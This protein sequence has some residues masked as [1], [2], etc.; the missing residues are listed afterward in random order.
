MVGRAKPANIDQHGTNIRIRIKHKGRTH[1]E[2]IAGDYHSPRD[3]AAAVRRRDEIKSR[4]RLGLP[5]VNEDQ[6]EHN[7][8]IADCQRYMDAMT[9]LDYSTALDY[10][11]TLNKH[12]IPA[13]ANQI[14]SEVT[15]Q[16]VK[17]VLGATGLSPKRKRNI[18]IPLRGVFKL[19]EIA[20][21]PADIQ[22]KRAPRRAIQ[23]FR[24]NEVAAIMAELTRR[25]DTQVTAYFA[26]LI[27]CGLRPGGEPLGLRW[28]DYD[29]KRLH[30]QRT[31]VR[32]RHKDTTKTHQDRKVF[33]PSWVRP[34]LNDL[35]SRFTGEWMFLNT[36]GRPYLDSDVFNAA[37]HKVFESDAIKR[38]LRMDYRIP[39]V[40]RHTRAAELLSTGVDA[41]RAARELGHSTEMFHRTYS[42]W[43]D[44]Y[45]A[46]DDDDLE[47][48]HGQPKTKGVQKLSREGED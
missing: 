31:I 4:I 36:A 1:V 42:E 7:L 28:S 15:T 13:F 40:C 5:I 27:G 44:E 32:R 45:G 30:V 46:N 35:P 43:L 39:Y 29:G 6:G 16:S 37:W 22:V 12:W 17:R 21:N 34:Y 41:A 23:R 19:A 8:F 48:V 9:D 2:I 24:P 3:L 25:G 38:K 47:G 14:T 26:T 20:P 10:E 18:L 11:N 33:V